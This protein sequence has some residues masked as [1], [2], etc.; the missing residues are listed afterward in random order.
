[1]DNNNKNSFD[2]FFSDLKDGH[3]DTDVEG[4]H[5][6]KYSQ[7]GKCAP[8]LYPASIIVLLSGHKIMHLGDKVC[9]Y[10]ANNYL[11]V[12]LALPALCETCASPEE[13]VTG[14]VI[15]LDTS[16]LR[17]LI[18]QMDIKDRVESEEDDTEDFSP[19]GPSAM[20]EMMLQCCV[21]LLNSLKNKRDAIVLGESIKREIV[22][23][24]LCG[25]Q[26]RML[27]KLASQSGKLA[28]LSSIIE[29]MKN[30]YNQSLD[31]ED[32]A[33]RANLSMSSFY[34]LFKSITSDTPMQYLKKIRLNKA[35]ELIVK[36][37]VKAY[38]AAVEVGYE[39][40]SQFSREFKRYFGETPASLKDYDVK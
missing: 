39:S 24:A 11:V 1:M 27:I 40:V 17:D 23:R 10:D 34:R 14:F 3:Y 4:V 19:I 2:L 28:K 8:V 9:T 15:E 18:R 29:H 38:A 21:R 30:N 26:A 12:S 25:A 16:G 7:Y 6:F 22:Y 37:N 13:P 36:N 20:D 32:L 33:K 31:V 35:R 5:L